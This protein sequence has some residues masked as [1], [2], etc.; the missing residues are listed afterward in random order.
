MSSMAQPGATAATRSM[1][2]MLGI[3]GTKIS[4]PRM[5]SAQRMANSTPCSSVIQKR[6]IVRSVTV[7]RPEARWAAKSGITLPRLPMTLP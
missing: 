4:P 3:F 1:I 2:R 7:T 5:R 6:V